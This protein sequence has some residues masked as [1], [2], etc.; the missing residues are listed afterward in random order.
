MR[1]RHGDDPESSASHREC[2]PGRIARAH[3]ADLGQIRRCCD[4]AAFGG[5]AIEMVRR[6]DERDD[7]SPPRLWS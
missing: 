7:G 6:L 1:E 4:T 5:R 3:M 2:R